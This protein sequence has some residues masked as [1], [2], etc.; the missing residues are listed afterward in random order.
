MSPAPLMHAND[1]EKMIEAS[2]L[3]YRASRFV[4]NGVF[5]AS[6][7]SLEDTS[8]IITALIAVHIAVKLDEEPESY[9]LDDMVKHVCIT[10]DLPV[11][12]MEWRNIRAENTTS[13][14]WE[15]IEAW[16]LKRIDYRCYEN[17]TDPDPVSPVSPMCVE[18]VDP[19]NL[20]N[21]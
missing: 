3:A 20:V 4:R 19:V 15:D 13:G 12:W 14:F 8:T 9:T 1:T 21:L 7:T 2:V 16:I 18:L 5:E 17:L 6:W 11:L 10:N